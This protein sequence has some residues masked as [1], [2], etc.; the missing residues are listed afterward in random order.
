MQILDTELRDVKI[1]IL[2]K[3]ED[4]RGCVEVTINNEEMARQGIHFVCKEQRIYHVSK[5][6]LFMEFIFRPKVIHRR[7]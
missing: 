1:L 5:K 4:I 2:D 3:R 6:E 7:K